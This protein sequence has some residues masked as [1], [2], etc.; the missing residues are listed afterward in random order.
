MSDVPLWCGLEALIG[1]L[2]RALLPALPSQ[3]SEQY[4]ATRSR[5]SR[6]PYAILQVY[7]LRIL[8]HFVIYD[9]GQVLLK[10]LLL[11]RCPSSP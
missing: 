11:S 4:I 10:H 6:C 8:V 7:A 5:R 1:V 9:S 2:H 3:L